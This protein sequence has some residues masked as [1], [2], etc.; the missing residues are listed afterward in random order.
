MGLL[1]KSTIPKVP[2]F[3]GLWCILGPGQLWWF[4]PLCHGERRGG[5]MAVPDEEV[6][7]VF[8]LF[9]QAADGFD[10]GFWAAQKNR[11]SW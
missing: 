2:P 5:A 11:V 6:E 8:K 1:I 7:E 3:I 9:D 10:F 4:L